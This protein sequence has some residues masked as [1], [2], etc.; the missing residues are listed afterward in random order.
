MPWQP[1]PAFIEG[2]KLFDRQKASQ[3][4]HHILP[5]RRMPFGKNKP[6]PLGPLRFFRP[7]LHDA[8]IKRHHNVHRREWPANVPGSASPNGAKTQP[9]PFPTDTSEL[10]IIYR[11][12]HIASW[13]N[14]FFELG[15]LGFR[16]YPRLGT[17]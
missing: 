2:F 5:D 4:H 3:R 16:R 6:V 8:K 1:R 7:D 12:T 13:V 15:V 9:P 10:L 11:A 14:I 17:A